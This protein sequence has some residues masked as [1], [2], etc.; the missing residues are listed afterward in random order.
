MFKKNNGSQR[1]Q[2]YALFSIGTHIRT[3]METNKEHEE[4]KER[5]ITRI[6]TR[7]SEE[8]TEENTRSN[9]TFTR[10]LFALFASTTKR[11]TYQKYLHFLIVGSGR[12]K[13]NNWEQYHTNQRNKERLCGE[14]TLSLSFVLLVLS[15]FLNTLNGLGERM[16]SLVHRVALTSCVS[17]STDPSSVCSACFVSM[18]KRGS[19]WGWENKRT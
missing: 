11:W 12:N 10:S 8:R 4:K 16:I 6:L 13:E 2:N 19:S 5:N 18:V 15:C 17:C 3:K 1:N 7:R 14:T 9:A